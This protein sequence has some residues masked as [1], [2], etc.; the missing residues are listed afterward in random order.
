VIGVKDSIDEK[1]LQEIGQ[2]PAINRVLQAK[3]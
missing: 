3:F 1:T 2:I